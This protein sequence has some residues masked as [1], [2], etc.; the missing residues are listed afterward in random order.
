MKQLFS[1][2]PHKIVPHTQYAHVLQWIMTDSFPLNILAS[3]VHTK[4]VFFDFDCLSRTKTD[5][6]SLTLTEAVLTIR[7]EGQCLIGMTPIQMIS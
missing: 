2:L 7:V 6:S 3:T 4:F 5:M 1:Q